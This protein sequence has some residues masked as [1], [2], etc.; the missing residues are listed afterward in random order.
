MITR[1]NIL[2]SLFSE[3]CEF[4]SRTL[5]ASV[6]NLPIFHL[7]F[8]RDVTLDERRIKAI[9]RL[10]EQCKTYK[11]AFI[12]APEHRLS[13]E[14]RAIELFRSG[15]RDLSYKLR[16]VC[17]PLRWRDVLDESDELLHHRYRLIYATGKVAE[18]PGGSHRY[19]ASQTLLSPQ[20][21]RLSKSMG[22]W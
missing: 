22:S 14:L 4:F 2:S 16:H 5:T 1:L 7:P 3:A 13:L 10:M 12:V 18:L 20:R 8:C 21:I 15:Q 17:D 6:A 9:T 11:G 19:K